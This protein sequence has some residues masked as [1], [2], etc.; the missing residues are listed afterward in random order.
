MI[1]DLSHVSSWSLLSSEKE[2]EDRDEPSLYVLHPR[3][4]GETAE[5]A[6]WTNCPF[7]KN[8]VSSLN[9]I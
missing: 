7:N 8:G 2:D 9:K 1:N 5:V 4:I 6:Q 3:E